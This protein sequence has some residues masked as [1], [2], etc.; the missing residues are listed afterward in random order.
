MIVEVIC[1]RLLL[2]AVVKVLLREGR[3]V[4]GCLG[5]F[6]SWVGGDDSGNDHLVS[7][8][9]SERHGLFQVLCPLW[10]RKGHQDELIVCIETLY[11][12]IHFRW[13]SIED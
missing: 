4:R 9:G 2:D 11:Y 7:L 1:L 10:K 5:I 6:V 8:I 3:N 12:P 13:D